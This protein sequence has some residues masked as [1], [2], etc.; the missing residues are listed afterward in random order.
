MLGEFGGR[1]GRRSNGKY[2]MIILATIVGGA[3]TL[4]GVILN[5]FL[6][7][8]AARKKDVRGFVA[9]YLSNQR[10]LLARMGALYSDMDRQN[11]TEVSDI[12]NEDTK[13]SMLSNEYF[14]ATQPIE[15][16][17]YDCID[18][19]SLICRYED[20]ETLEKMKE[21]CGVF[22]LHTIVTKTHKMLVEDEQRDSA[23]GEQREST[24][25]FIYVF[26]LAKITILDYMKD[27]EQ[28]FHNY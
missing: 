11:E 25:T 7:R 27:I 21:L 28:H 5:H 9:A 20:N 16:K 1:A 18:K 17:L 13:T 4:I 3:L 22:P 19:L 12:D 15:D 2:R 24:L 23:K 6:S 10:R 26:S 14:L 8:S